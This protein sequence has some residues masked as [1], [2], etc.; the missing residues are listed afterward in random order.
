MKNTVRLTTAVLMLILA[1]GSFP[2]S[3]PAALSTPSLPELMNG[4]K[5]PEDVEKF[6]RRHFNFRE[7]QQLFGTFDYWQTP[8]EFW[9]KR[10]GDCEDFAIF[11][12]YALQK[13]GIDAHVVSI[14]GRGGY[15]HTVTLFVDGDGY[16]V[17]NE[18]RLYRFRS[19]NLEDVL[20]RLYPEWTWAAVAEQRGTRGFLLREIRNP[21]LQQFTRAPFP[22]PGF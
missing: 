15:A 16:S 4:L 13:L 2:V 7:D 10:A 22:V 8:E 18:D 17:M 14:Y 11:S 19:R 20:T 5:S 12:Q 9:Q 3:S 6:L 21:R 1:L